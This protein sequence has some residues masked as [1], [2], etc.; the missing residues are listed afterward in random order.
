MNEESRICPL[1][2]WMEAKGFH[3]AIVCKCSHHHGDHTGGGG[4]KLCQ[5]DRYDQSWVEK[6][7]KV[8]Q[9]VHVAT[10]I[11]TTIDVAKLQATSTQVGSLSA[12]L[13]RVDKLRAKAAAKKAEAKIDGAV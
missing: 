7:S 6:E 5:C 13:H 3:H 11:Q 10:A 8:E 12:V 1:C 9:E 4:C 2:P